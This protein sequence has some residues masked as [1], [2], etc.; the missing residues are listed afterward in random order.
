MH[1]LRDFAVNRSELGDQS[2]GEHNLPV[3]RMGVRDSLN[4]VPRRL[5]LQN[6]D[7]TYRPRF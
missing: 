6:P 7:Y 2:S 4:R 3:C 1:C 5:L